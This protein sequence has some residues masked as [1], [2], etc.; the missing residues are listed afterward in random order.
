MIDEDVSNAVAASAAVWTAVDLYLA[1][2]AAAYIR[3]YKPD[4]LDEDK[5]RTTEASRVKRVRRMTTSDADLEE[6]LN[7]YKIAYQ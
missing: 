2:L 5:R 1:T 4:F 3:R 6:D 7:I